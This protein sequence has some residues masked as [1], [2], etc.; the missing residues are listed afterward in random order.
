VFG[1]HISSMLDN[2]IVRQVRI[3]VLYIS[4]LKII[5]WESDIGL[6]VHPDG[7]GIPVSDQDPL[8]YVE[9]TLQHD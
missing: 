8:S 9:L 3:S 2:T 6:S 4:E 5:G 1:H 7:K